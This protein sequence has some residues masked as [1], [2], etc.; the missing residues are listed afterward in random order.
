MAALALMLLAAALVAGTALG[1]RASGRAA[2]ARDAILLAD[3]EWRA[4]AATRIA[5]WS[6]ADD[7]LPI[8]QMRR[9]TVGPRA[10]GPNSAPVTTT[11]RL[12]RLS[13][14]R[15]AMAMDCQVGPDSAVLARRRVRLLLT[16]PP[17]DS[18]NPLPRPKP[19]TN[20]SLADVF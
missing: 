18:L 5:A 16:L 2:L 4:V 3:H 20:W 15:V 10:R 1:S 19:L 17:A 14:S 6:S 9:T 8:G 7:S 11:I 13:A 12:Y